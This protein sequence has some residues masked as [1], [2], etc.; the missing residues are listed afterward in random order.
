FNSTNEMESRV[1]SIQSHVVSG[2]CGNKSAVFPLQTLGFEVDFINS[3]QFSNH[4]G[5]GTWTGQVLHESELLELFSGLKKNDL[6]RN[7]TH[8]LTGYARSSSFLEAVHSVISE[9]KTISPNAIYLCDPV[10]GDE[11]KLYVPEELVPIYR[12]RIVPLADVVTPNQ[13]EAELLTGT[14]ITDIKSAITAI[15]V[16]HA[17]GI[18]T[19]VISST[20]LSFGGA[21]GGSSNN[22]VAIASSTVG[23]GSSSADT[24]AAAVVPQRFQIAIPR[25]DATF[26]GTGDLFAALFLAWLTK[27]NFDLKRTLENV[28]A[29]LQA[30]IKRTYA[31]AINRPGGIKSWANIELKTIQGRADIL[32]PNVE[33]AA[34]EVVL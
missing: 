33:I 26:I 12:D 21:A 29:S 11:G 28:V 1:L 31:F 8:I 15:D 20:E 19:V 30:V 9:I 2:I 5:Y 13:F 24:A 25:F 17:K 14:K 34:E 22:L 10:L 7:Y 32:Q 3:V 18:K 27:T 23:R 4:T 16:L 6:H